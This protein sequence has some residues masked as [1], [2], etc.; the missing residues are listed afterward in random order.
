MKEE[1]ETISEGNSSHSSS[2]WQSRPIQN[3]QQISTSTTLMPLRAHKRKDKGLSPTRECNSSQIVVDHGM[4]FQI[5][6]DT[7]RVAGREI[8]EEISRFPELVRVN[9][10]WWKTTSD[11]EMWFA[12]LQP[13]EGAE[14]V[15]RRRA[16]LNPSLPAVHCCI[17]LNE[18]QL[19]GPELVRNELLI[20][21]C[22][23]KPEAPI[24]QRCPFFCRC[25][26]DTMGGKV[27]LG[28]F[29]LQHKGVNVKTF[30]EMQCDSCGEK[31]NQ[32]TN[33]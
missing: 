21:S 27:V 9:R 16:L 25:D 28:R 20:L 33:G 23:E 31:I 13:D 17:S 3:Q 8:P 18:Q 19:E 30:E 11:R 4:T 29:N 15:K 14:Q 32:T 1:E 22:S 7:F 12:K 10:E 24:A 26:E 5:P 6:T 2:S